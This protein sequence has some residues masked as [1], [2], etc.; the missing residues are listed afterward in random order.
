MI[1]CVWKSYAKN[2]KQDKSKKLWNKEKHMKTKKDRRNKRKRSLN[3]INKWKIRRDRNKPIRK[4]KGDWKR[5]DQSTKE[6]KK[7]NEGISN[8][9]K[10][11]RKNKNRKHI[12]SLPRHSGLKIKRLEKMLKEER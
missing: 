2:R 1:K 5:K 3:I 7:N 9:T 10:K 8:N 11:Q 6:E 4:N 12:Q